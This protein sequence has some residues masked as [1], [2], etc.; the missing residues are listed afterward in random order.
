M[1]SAVICMSP[2][3]VWHLC[4]LPCVYT[5]FRLISIQRY[6][7]KSPQICFWGTKYEFYCEHVADLHYNVRRAQ[8][9]LELFEST[10]GRSRGRSYSIFQTETIIYFQHHKL[11]WRH[12]TRFV[13]VFRRRSLPPVFPWRVGTATRRLWLGI[14]VDK[15]Q[16]NWSW[17]NN[18]VVK[19]A[20]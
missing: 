9:W 10:L 6:A 11:L 20:N 19:Q 8:L 3:R 7:S 15:K 2:R 14:L 13:S 1:V 18:V 17:W 4:N 12:G 16:T 5:L